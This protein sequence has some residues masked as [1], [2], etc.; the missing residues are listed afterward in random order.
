MQI[1]N[2]KCPIPR[3]HCVK[4][5]IQISEYFEQSGVQILEVFC[6]T[7]PVMLEVEALGLFQISL[8]LKAVPLAPPP[9]NHKY[10]IPINPLLHSPFNAF[11]NRADPD[12]ATVVRA[13]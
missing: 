11:V 1:D 4:N 3:I 6:S 2:K 10:N 12:Q 13:A 9:V 8:V 7:I 5:L